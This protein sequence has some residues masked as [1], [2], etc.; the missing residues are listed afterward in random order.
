MAG[1]GIERIPDSLGY[2]VLTE[3]GAVVSS[4]GELENDET[5]ATK[6]SKMVLTAVRLVN[7]SEKKDA[8]KRLSVVYDNFLY[9]ATVSNHRILVSKRKYVPQD[10]VAA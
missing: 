2:L 3:D 7:T 5:V 9:A 1:Q 8:F 10:P 4:G 6:I